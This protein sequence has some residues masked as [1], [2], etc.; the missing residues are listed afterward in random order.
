TF[1]ISEGLHMFVQ[2]I[3][4]I[5]LLSAPRRAR[6]EKTDLSGGFQSTQWI[7]NHSQ[8]T[9]RSNR[10]NHQFIQVTSSG[11]SPAV[12][13]AKVKN[14]ALNREMLVSFSPETSRSGTVSFNEFRPPAN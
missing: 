2:H 11:P 3:V 7:T 1:W 12:N 6:E 8:F 4:L 10:V 5:N 13:R 14:E 9:R